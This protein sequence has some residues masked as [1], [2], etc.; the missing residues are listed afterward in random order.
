MVWCAHHCLLFNFAN[1]KRKASGVKMKKFVLL[2][3]VFSLLLSLASCK[4]FKKED[5]A[6]TASDVCEVAQGSEPT[7]TITTV[8]YTTNSGD[9]LSGY[10]KTVTDGTNVIFEYYYEKLATPEESLATG[11]GRRV[12]PYEGTIYYTDGKYTSGDSESWRPGTGTA[13]DLK[14]NFNADLFK[15]A[16][17][18]ESGE[19]LEATLGASE[20]VAFIGTDLNMVGDAT[21]TIEHNGTNLTSITV[22]CSTANGKLSIRNSYTYNKQDLSAEA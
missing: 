7:K 6:P 3:L 2:L 12:V 14:L 11:D 17:V 16:T 19:R 4:L 5:E 20:L 13:F 15:N 22:S 21:V 18:S 10:Y 8:S 1:K 9:V